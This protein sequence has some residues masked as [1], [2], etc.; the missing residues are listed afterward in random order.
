MPS[1]SLSTTSPGSTVACPIRIGTLIPIS[2]TSAIADGSNPRQKIWNPLISDSPLTSR[3]APST[4]SPVPVFVQIDVPRLSP[5]IVPSLIFPNRSTTI[6]SR[7]TSVSITHEFCP[8]LTR[9]SFFAWSLITASMSG[10]RGMNTAVTA[11][12]TSRSPTGSVTFTVFQLRSNWLLYPSLRSVPHASSAVVSF[13]RSSTSSGTFGRPSGNRSPF[14][15]RVMSIR[16]S[17]ENIP[18]CPAALCKNS[19]AAL[20]TIAIFFID[21]GL[22]SLSRQQHFER[23][24]SRGAALTRTYDSAPPRPAARTHTASPAAPPP[25][26]AAARASPP[27]G[28]GR[29]PCLQSPPPRT[30]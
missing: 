16:C 23:R 8:R 28:T 15:S 17:L 11:R 21:S 26:S 19:A 29:L 7:F 22:P 9:F 13:R 10:R 24:R 12:P 1:G 18:S 30:Q 6:T 3:T 20:S 14:H 2:V 27:R 25:A 5:M 4:T